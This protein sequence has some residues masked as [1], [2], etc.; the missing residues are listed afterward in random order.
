MSMAIVAAAPAADLAVKAP[1]PVWSWTGCYIG[2]NFGGASARIAT[3]DV[4]TNPPTD[5]GTMYNPGMLGGGQVGCDVQAGR[6]VFGVEGEFDG[7][8]ISGTVID[9]NTGLP[10]SSRIKWLA[11]ATGR[12]GYLFGA[13]TLAYA[14]GGGAWSR[15]SLDI[16]A[17]TPPFTATDNRSGWTAGAGIEQRFLP[18]VYGFVEYNFIEFG[19]KRLQF[20]PVFPHSISENIQEILVGINFRFGGD[21][22]MGHK[23]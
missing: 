19:S 8:N 17:A 22:S 5:T 10:S 16:D 11:T 21:G 6:F 9:F 12:L 7:A 15:D 20:T 3:S 1:E 4:T 13:G 18:N 23:Y 14:R 2:A